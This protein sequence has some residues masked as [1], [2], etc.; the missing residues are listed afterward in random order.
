MVITC[1][2]LFDGDLFDGDPLDIRS[3]FWNSKHT[4]AKE[5]L[6]SWDNTN[7]LSSHMISV[8]QFRWR[9]IID[10]SKTQAEGQTKRILC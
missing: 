6:D 8:F 7:D 5:T 4:A 1:G 9:S 10:C 3:E 2:D